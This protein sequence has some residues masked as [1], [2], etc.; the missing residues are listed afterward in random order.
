MSNPRTNVRQQG[1][2]VS[3]KANEK[4]K[5]REVVLKMR[6]LGSNGKGLCIYIY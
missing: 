1:K 5:K 3:L 6:K 2:N 4:K